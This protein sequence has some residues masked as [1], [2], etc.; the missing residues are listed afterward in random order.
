MYYIDWRT[1]ISTNED[2]QNIIRLGYYDSLLDG[3]L[4]NTHPSLISYASSID[5]VKD[6]CGRLRLADQYSDGVRSNFLSVDQLRSVLGSFSY[7]SYE[8]L[9]SY[10]FLLVLSESMKSVGML[11]YQVSWKKV[12]VRAGRTLYGIR[13]YAFNLRGISAFELIIAKDKM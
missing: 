10:C 4:L 3:A 9:R 6:V 11:L 12:K 13:N 1:R 7:D 8:R 2:L 5:E